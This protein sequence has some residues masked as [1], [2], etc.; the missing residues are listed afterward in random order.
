MPSS[1]PSTAIKRFLPLVLLVLGLI[2]FF[3][4]DLHK[5]ISFA[6][7]AEHYNTIT[8]WVAENIIIAVVGF[9]VIYT[10]SVAFSLPIA[11][12]LTLTGGAVLGY[13]AAPIIIVAATL[14]ALALFLAARGALADTLAT[15][16]GPFMAKIS[17]G[18]NE[19]PFLWLLALRLIPAAPF[20]VVNIVPALLGMKTRQY[21]LATFIGI[22]PGTTVYV[23]VGRGF[24]AIL[25]AGETPDLSVL[26]D[27]RI[28][29]PLVGLGVLA[30]IPIIAEKLL[31]KG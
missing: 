25:S 9:F 7:L 18:F 5:L 27:P 14:G 22:A 3:V 16:A 30:L 21:L 4:F 13:Y 26:S 1:P 6:V 28:L 23:A 29:A 8:A 17:D 12:L 19:R 15:R 24:D 20:W 31:K 10:V 2:V 11:S